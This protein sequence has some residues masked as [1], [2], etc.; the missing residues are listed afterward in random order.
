MCSGSP[1]T[2]SESLRLPSEGHAPDG[3]A[4]PWEARVG[5]EF[6][7][8]SVVIRVWDPHQSLAESLGAVLDQDYPRRRDH[9][10]GWG[11][12]ARAPPGRGGA[13]GAGRHR[14]LAGSVAIA[15]ARNRGIREA[16]GEFVAF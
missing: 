6:P 8:I 2:G 12:D 1:H 15:E 10:R 7:L 4:R 5:Q 11:A 13:G 14:E 3:I 9:R 16:A